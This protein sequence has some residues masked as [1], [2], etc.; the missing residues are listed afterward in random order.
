MTR[1][2][3]PYRLLVAAGAPAPPDGYFYRIRMQRYSDHLVDVEVRCDG[4]LLGS[5]AL[6]KSTFSIVENANR[7]VLEAA[8]VAAREAFDAASAAG[9]ARA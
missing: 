7:T 2:H 5:V 6:G 8:S 1:H 9:V 3:A 4:E